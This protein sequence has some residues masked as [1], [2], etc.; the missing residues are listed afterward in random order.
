LNHL[1]PNPSSFHTPHP[2]SSPGGE[3]LDD[4]YSITYTP[5]PSGEGDG[6]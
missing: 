6:G 1:T 3:G 2:N 4:C 5:S